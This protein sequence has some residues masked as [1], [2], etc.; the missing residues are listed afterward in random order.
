MFKPNLR[1]ESGLQKVFCIQLLQMYF[2]L[3]GTWSAPTCPFAPG[4]SRRYT[5]TTSVLANMCAGLCWMDFEQS[6]E[7]F[8]HVIMF[9]KC[10]RFVNNFYF[11]FQPVWLP[12][13][14]QVIGRQLFHQKEQQ[15]L[16]D[17]FIKAFQLRNSLFVHPLILLKIAASRSMSTTPPGQPS[18]TPFTRILFPRWSMR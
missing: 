6:F 5:G 7:N 10:Q 1:I 2:R 8:K 13:F 14:L 15:I 18:R 4:P 16:D 11:Y 12:P 3:G 17:S 9:K